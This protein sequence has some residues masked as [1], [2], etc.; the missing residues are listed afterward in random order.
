MTKWEY[1][2]VLG[3]ARRVEAEINRL[4]AEGWEFASMYMNVF[5]SAVLLKRQMANRSL[6]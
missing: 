5:N 1:K 4:G 6:P 3:N 2:F